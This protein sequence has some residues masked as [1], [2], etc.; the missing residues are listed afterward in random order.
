MRTIN[1]EQIGAVSL[2]LGCLGSENDLA[3]L[4]EVAYSED[5]EYIP[6]KFARL[7]SIER[8]DDATREAEFYEEKF[9]SLAEM[10]EG[11]SYDEI[12]IPKLKDFPIRYPITKYNCVVLLYNF[13]YNQKVNVSEQENCYFEFIGSVKY[14]AQN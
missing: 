7:F 1:M 14:E 9:S 6:S 11:F 2:W 3:E 4:L 13:A 10:L 12:I 5:G 8:Y